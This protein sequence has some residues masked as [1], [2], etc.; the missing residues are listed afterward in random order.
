MASA[1]SIAIGS[2]SLTAGKT[3]KKISCNSDGVKGRKV[4]IS[5]R[6]STFLATSLKKESLVEEGSD[7]FGTRMSEGKLLVAALDF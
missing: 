3:E 6:T 2:S 5:L 7:F 4:S 1:N